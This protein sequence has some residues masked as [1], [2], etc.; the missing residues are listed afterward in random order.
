V[1]N[2]N[3]LRWTLIG[4]LSLIVAVYLGE[5]IFGGHSSSDDEGP[6]SPAVVVAHRYIPAFTQIN[7]SEVAVRNYPKGFVPPGALHAV[8]ELTRENGLPVYVSAVAIPE[9]QPITRSLVNDLGKSHGMA[10]IL[11][12]GKVAVS[13]SVA[14]VRGVGGWIQPGDT[15]AIFGT[16][17][18]GDLHAVLRRQTQLLFSAV[19]VLAVDKKRL[20]SPRADTNS[21]NES[22]ENDSEGNILTVLMNPLEAARLVESR[23]NG[24]LSVL[25]RP[26]GD[27]DLWPHMSSGSARE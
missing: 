4:L 26:V 7:P 6:D 25:L 14:P 23:E 19:H 17:Q 13:F 24:H 22:V 3:A 5:G 2:P 12:P 1:K 8:S 9:G 10:S 11:A 18:E 15:I 20:G 21:P 16:R 27:D